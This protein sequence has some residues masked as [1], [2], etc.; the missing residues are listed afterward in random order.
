MATTDVDVNKIKNN[1]LAAY[2]ILKFSKAD[3]DDTEI[4]D[5]ER[6]CLAIKYLT[7][8]QFES[9]DVAAYLLQRNLEDYQDLMEKRDGVN[10]YWK[11]VRLQISK[12]TNNPQKWKSG[13]CNVDTALNF[14]K[15]LPCQ[16]NNTMPCHRRVF[17]NRHIENIINIWKNKETAV[18]NR[19]VSTPA[20]PK[21]SPGPSINSKGK[22]EDNILHEVGTSS[23]SST[24]SVDENLSV[25]VS[26]SK[27]QRAKSYPVNQK[28]QSPVQQRPVKFEPKSYTK[29]SKEESF[30]KF[31]NNH[32][33]SNFYKNNAKSKSQVSV[34][35]N[36]EDSDTKNKLNSFK[37]ARD[38][39]SVQQIKANRPMQKKTLGGKA[40]INS[41]FVC[42]FKREKEKAQQGQGNMYNNETDTMDIEDERLKNIEPKMVELIKNE[43]MD[44]K[45]TISWDNIAGLEYAKKIIK[46]VV[47]YPM[48]RPDIFTGLR[49]PPKGIL[50]FGPPGTGKT[51]IGKC[52][53]SQ[54]KSTFFSI[55]ASSLT[56]K[57]IGEGEKMVRALFAVARVYQPSVIFVDEIDSLLTQ[58]SETEH[59]SSRRLKT[60]FLVQLDGAATAEED[61]ILIVGA[62]NRPQELDEAARR[63][64]VKRL[65]VPLPEFQARKQIVNNLLIT[66]PHNLSEEEVNNIAEQSQGYSGADMSNLCKEASMG[67]IRSIPFSQLED[68]RK[69]DVRQVTLDDFKE[70]LIHMR[71]SVSESSLTAYAEWD[72]IYGTGT[73]HN[74]KV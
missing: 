16:D 52:I 62:T 33:P 46:E 58:R 67:P 15:P 73:A 21:L 4:V 61:R 40:S 64:L 11:Q 47:V 70:A 48:L 8:K 42:P 32:E 18:R 59:E 60:E 49:R 45:T 74:Y 41:Q 50:L 6:R 9:E 25:Q 17:S 39:L 68:I 7:A 14:V 23:L 31:K 37:T 12:T 56:S 1:F 36:E 27:L 72:A 3:K 28:S 29:F 43:I 44:S 19:K 57:W 24:R 55:S 35:Q 53:A 20:T 30:K 34:Q 69:E 63:R 10:N 38:E 65:Y 71:P 22:L 5:I 2:H 66:I 26:Y 54:S 51:L 13:L